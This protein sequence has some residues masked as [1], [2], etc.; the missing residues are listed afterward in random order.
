MKYLGLIRLTT[1]YNPLKCESGLRSGRPKISCLSIS[2]PKPELCQSKLEPD[3][4]H[5]YRAF[6]FSKE[7]GI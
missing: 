1:L 2:G 5:I 7:R 4:Q 6:F 3:M